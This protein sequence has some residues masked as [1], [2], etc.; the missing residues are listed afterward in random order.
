MC[1]EWNQQLVLLGSTGSIGTQ[2]ISVCKNLGMPIKT[3]T[4]GRNIALLEQQARACSVQRVVVADETRYSALKRALADTDI[5]VQAGRQAIVEAAAQSAG[6]VLNAI[7]GIA[8]LRATLAALESGAKLALANKESLVTGGELVMEALRQHGGTLIPVDSEHSAIFQCLQC[9][10]RRDLTSILL[11][12]SGGP[13][14]GKTKQELV[15]VGIQETIAHPNWRMGAKISVDS[16]TMMNKGLELMEAMWLFGLAPEQIDIVVHRQSVVHSAVAFADGSVIAQMGEPDMR[17]AIQYAMTYPR[18][19]AFG[20]RQLSLP[21]YK[22]LQ[23]EEPDWDTFSCLSTCLTAARTGGLAPTVANG[24]NEE[25]VALFLQ[26]KI[27]F[28]QIGEL[29][30][31]AVHTMQIHTPVSLDAIEQADQA[32]RAYVRDCCKSI[33]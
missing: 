31:G 22:T 14:V 12:A 23:F 18:R 29:V 25:A 24:A 5:E 21:Q 27:G 2:T 10:D 7:V 33:R 6:F 8:G 19:Y 15:H 30:A 1:D 4:A 26:D 11:T 13:F 9:G 28:L 3:L 16:A 20:G 32:A 17:T